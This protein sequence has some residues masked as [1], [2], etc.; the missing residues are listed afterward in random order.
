V[1]SAVWRA[2]ATTC[3]REELPHSVLI[4]VLREVVHLLSVWTEELGD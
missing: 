2:A 4:Q 1:S 3:R